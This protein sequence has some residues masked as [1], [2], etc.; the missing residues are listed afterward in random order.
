MNALDET[1]APTTMARIA[2]RRFLF[3]T[4]FFVV[5]SVLVFAWDRIRGGGGSI[6]GPDLMISLFAVIAL[7]GGSGISVR[8]ARKADRRMIIDDERDRA[9]A[10]I[11]RQWTLLGLYAL[12]A[13]S[14]V[15]FEWSFVRE[16][17]PMA[18]IRDWIASFLLVL[19]VVSLWLEALICVMLY[20][21]DGDGD[22]EGEGE[23]ES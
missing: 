5:P 7:W 6:V 20:R 15:A 14:I 1:T 23:G 21:R 17:W 19:L 13:L 10:A 9:I 16:R 2:W 8:M 22:G 4:L 18:D 12:L 3:L 11:A